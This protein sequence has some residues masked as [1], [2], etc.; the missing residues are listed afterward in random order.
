MTL[1]MLASGLFWL[2]MVVISWLVIA[3]QEEL[4]SVKLWDKAAHTLAFAA[5]T[6]LCAIAYRQRVGLVRISLL[7]FTFGLTIEM[8]QYLLPYR[9]FSLLDMLANGLGILVALPLIVPIEKL[10]RLNTPETPGVL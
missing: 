3:P 7:L 10:F 5:L 1:R 4:P 6:L 2:C 9:Q 8:V